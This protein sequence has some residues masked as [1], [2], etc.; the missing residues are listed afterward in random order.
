MESPFVLVQWLPEQVETEREHARSH[1]RATAIES[2]RG[3]E[4][5]P[6][7]QDALHA[8]ERADL[9]MIGLVASVLT[10]AAANALLISLSSR[11]S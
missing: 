4:Q 3:S 11:K 5:T 9:V 10:S 1:A 8:R 6:E 2:K 7:T